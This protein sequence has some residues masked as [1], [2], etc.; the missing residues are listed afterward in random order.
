MTQLKL[1]NKDYLD[2]FID[3]SQSVMPIHSENAPPTERLEWWELSEKDPA[4][5]ALKEIEEIRLYNQKKNLLKNNYLKIG[6]S[7]RYSKTLLNILERKK[8]VDE[9][10]IS[11]KSFSSYYEET[12]KTHDELFENP[13]NFYQKNKKIRNLEK[14]IFTFGSLSL[15]YSFCALPRLASSIIKDA[16]SVRIWHE[17]MLDTSDENHKLEDF[18]DFLMGGMK[19]NEII[20]QKYEALVKDLRGNK[21]PENLLKELF[22]KIKYDKRE[23]VNIW[24]GNAVITKSSLI[25]SFYVFFGSKLG[26]D[27][28]KKWRSKKDK[29]KLKEDFENQ[30]YTNPYI[31]LGLVDLSLRDFGSEKH[32]ER[33]KRYEGRR[34][35]EQD[36]GLIE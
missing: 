22:E 12:I 31:N 15:S 27:F 14:N 25:D 33:A 21:V 11:F 18:D 7:D 5:H 1:W 3:L 17:I 29:E 9:G 10:I 36:R 2:K 23:H 34:Y 16:E 4:Y 19:E 8:L 26:S 32:L 13:A 24:F 28:I 6:F 30:I 35:D 20:D